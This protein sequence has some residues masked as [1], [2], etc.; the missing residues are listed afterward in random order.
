MK[1]ITTLLL[2][3]FTIVVLVFGQTSWNN[4]IEETVA[5]ESK[6]KQTGEKK[7]MNTEKSTGSLYKNVK[8]QELKSALEKGISK[9]EK[10]NVLIAGSKALGDQDDG[11]GE[12][13]SQELQEEFEEGIAVSH[14]EF[15]GTST[16]LIETGLI[17]DYQDANP[18]VLILE[19]FTLADNGVV[20][21]EENHENIATI[22]QELKSINENLFAILMP[23]HPIPNAII[24]P[25]QVDALKEYAA[26]NNITYIDHWTE[27]PDYMNEAELMEYLKEDKSAP[28]EQGIQIW[29]KEVYELFGI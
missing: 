27:W 28:N 24:Y 6:K 1:Y 21:V 12:T 2:P 26:E 17:S 20:E 22:I 11:L 5:M 9:H 10:A 4:Q 13:I 15:N 25:T 19:A 23:P 16:E 18:D 14:I 8:N 7:E 29:S 3:L